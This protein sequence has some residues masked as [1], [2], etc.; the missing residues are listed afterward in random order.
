[1]SNIDIVAGGD[2][3]ETERLGFAMGRA[4]R[5]RPEFIGS[6]LALWDDANPGRP[7]QAELRCDEGQA[8]RLAVTPRPK[9]GDLAQAAMSLAAS[10]GVD[11]L[12]L[13]NILRFAESSEAFAAANDDGE[14]LMAALDVEDE[15]DS[16]D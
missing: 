15:E 16:N 9:D 3:A 5:S 2:A 6:A 14:M 12:A 10:L 1:M 11:P 4:A 13:V 7:A 8:W